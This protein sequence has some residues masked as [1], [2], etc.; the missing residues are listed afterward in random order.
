M[1]QNEYYS[2]DLFSGVGGLSHGMTK[3]GFKVIAAIEIDKD[4]VVTYKIN[5]P[6]VEVFD[7]DIKQVKIS[8]IKK[9]LNGQE[10]DLL[11]GCP[12]CQGF[13]SV[14]R[15]NK[16]RNIKDSRNAL[17]NEFLRFVKGLKPKTILMENV[18]GLIN[19]YQFNEFIDELIKLGYQNAENYKV[20][21]MK[22][23]EIPQRRKRF[24]LV[25]SRIGDISIAE[26][27]KNLVTV[28]NKIG[29]LVTPKS[30]KDKLHR[31]V[32]KHSKAVLNIIKHIPK[33]GGSRKDLPDELIYD[34]HRKKNVGFNDIYGRLKWNDVAPTITG[35]CLNPSKGR[36]L[37]PTQNR[38]ITPREAALLQSFPKT[39]KFPTDIS[40]TSLALL[41]GNALPP[42]FA[43]IQ[44]KA[45]IEHLTAYSSNDK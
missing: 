45:I 8:E 25:A 30:T 7:T 23:Y 4:A 20:V 5:H 35:G 38:C 26:G 17:I 34:C 37:H 15:K 21:N 19:Y 29:K 12:P 11:A 13:S 33:D 2:V 40:R 22:D 43:Y 39:Y 18:P 28:R 27:N 44:S 1:R 10:L 16:R 14:R 42:K 31:M 41:I 3:A 6:G 36:F 9:L 24:T 32:T